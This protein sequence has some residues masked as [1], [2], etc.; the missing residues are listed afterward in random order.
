M[1][2]AAAG[3]GPDSLLGPREA[4]AND[5]ANAAWG[6][7]AGGGGG[8]GA[9]ERRGVV[10][11]EGAGEGGAVESEEL[12]AVGG[13]AGVLGLGVGGE[14]VGLGLGLDGVAVGLEA[15]DGAVGVVDLED[16]VDGADGVLLLLPAGLEDYLHYVPARVLW[17]QLR[18]CKISNYPLNCGLISSFNFLSSR[19]F[20]SLTNKERFLLNQACLV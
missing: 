9:A 3:S 20:S 13:A 18:H 16:A 8:G 4:V 1:G 10:G 12:V 15:G 6:G 7:G 11:A 17:S 2:P 19:N 14:E 5:A